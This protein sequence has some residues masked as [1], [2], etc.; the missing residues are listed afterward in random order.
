VRLGDAL[1]FFLASGIEDIKEGDFAIDVT[2]LLIRI[3][4]ADC[5][6]RSLGTR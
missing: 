6:T 2:F 5:E 4:E 1:I 3:C